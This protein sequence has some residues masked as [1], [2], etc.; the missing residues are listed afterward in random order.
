MD[1]EQPTHAIYVQVV[2]ESQRRLLKVSESTNPYPAWSPTGHVIYVDGPNTS[3]SIWAL[4]FSLSKLSPTGSAF[5]IVERGSA[6][7]VSATD[8]L[9]YGDPPS[10]RV[11]LHWVDRSGKSLSTIGEPRVQGQPVLSRDG[12]RV[13]LVIRDPGW[14]VSVYDAERGTPTQ[15]T[16]DRNMETL[17]SWAPFGDEITYVSYTTREWAVMSKRPGSDVGPKQWLRLPSPVR[18]PE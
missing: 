4:P 14:D 1:G 3:P 13:V 5:P 11:Q 8:T 16:S 6:P 7:M 9:V 17:G 2:G 15:L 10:S 18:D 12:R